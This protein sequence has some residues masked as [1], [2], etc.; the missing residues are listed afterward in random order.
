MG[1]CMIT[2][3]A[4]TEKK[5]LHCTKPFSLQRPLCSIK[6]SL[7]KRLFESLKKTHIFSDFSPMW[8]ADY[9]RVVVQYYIQSQIVDLT[10]SFILLDEFISDDRTHQKIL[11]KKRK[12]HILSGYENAIK[13]TGS[14]NPSNFSSDSRKTIKKKPTNVSFALVTNYNYCRQNFVMKKWI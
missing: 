11:G 5:I 4:K 9:N 2:S 12:S 10:T 3:K 6:K 7:K 1:G 13:E 14:V 8:S